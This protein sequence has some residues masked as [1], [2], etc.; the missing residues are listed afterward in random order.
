MGGAWAYEALSFG[1]YWAWDPVENMSLVPWLILVAGIHTNLIAR[2][3]DNAIKSTYIYYILTFLMIVYSTFLTRSGILGDTSV[4]AFTK[5][6]LEWQLV[7]FLVSFT[8]LGVAMFFARIG[9]IPTTIKEEEASSREFWMFIGTLTLMFS[10]VLITFTTSI[11]VYNKISEAVGQP[12][13]LS[14]PVDVIDHYNKYQLWIGVFISLLSAVAIWFRYKL[15]FSKKI[16]TH[17]GV[18]VV[19]SAILTFLG[20]KWINAV[21]W[22]YQLLL[23][24]SIF[25]TISN[26]DYMVSFMRNNLKSAGSAISHLGFGLMIIGTLASGLN[27]LFIS[28][29]PFAQEGLIEGGDKDF[30][31]KNILLLKDAP[32]TMSG[33]EVTYVKDTS[34]SFTR[35]FLV[36]YKKRDDAGKITEEFDLTP[37]ILYDKTFTKIAASN[38]STKHY[39]NKDI[40]THV[41]S[42]P[43]AD[44]DADYRRQAEDS[45]KYI[46]YKAKVGDTIF[47]KAYYAVIEEVTLNPQ[48]KDYHREPN[49]IAVGLKMAVRK[50][51]IDSTWYAEP[52]LVLREK[53]VYSFP[54][55]L[56]LLKVKVKLPEEIFE[57]ILA[58]DEQ[59]KYTSFQLRRGQE[60]TFKDLTIKLADFDKNASHPNYEPVA[61]DV[62]VNA[63]LEVTN[64]KGIK[65]V[66]KPLFI[67]RDNKPFSLKDEV[68]SLGL[69]TKFVGVN[70]QTEMATIQIAQNENQ[71]IP[72]L[73]A[74]NVGR[75]DYIVLQAIEFPGINYFW[76]GSTLMMLGLLLSMVHRIRQKADY[77]WK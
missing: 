31:K 37:N 29:N 30:T 24:A 8:V 63:V 6:G 16:Y 60:V 28:N 19:V 12:L 38:P 39:W 41:S 44:L 51:D 53:E 50:L 54:A 47:T 4:H 45:L 15:G 9:G 23:F 72:V 33:Y 56:G 3:T 40:F 1:G 17:L 22:Q 62:G 70:P 14:P 74:E 21:A 18:A 66:S 42:L 49:D 5:M 13:K 48:S 46:A 67:I 11:P 27:K 58:S 36:N 2:N 68:V 52:I 10:A 26:A 20:T 43:K 57:K 61:G 65:N 77:T 75:S 64:K 34:W 32:M 7:I 59:L 73:I 55:Q 35:Q 25:T 69:H 76:V 71:E